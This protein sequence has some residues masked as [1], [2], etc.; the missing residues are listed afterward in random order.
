MGEQKVAYG[1]GGFTPFL[2]VRW[3]ALCELIRS[4]ISVGEVVRGLRSINVQDKYPCVMVHNDW[5]LPE[6]NTIG[7]YDKRATFVIYVVTQGNSGE[8]A[9]SDCV[10]IAEMVEKLLSNNALNDLAGAAP[11]FKYLNYPSYW[12]E[13]KVGQMKVAPP[14]PVQRDAGSFWIVTTRIPFEINWVEIE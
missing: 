6:L 4:N 10:D 2:K 1:P 14:I 9:E 7:K 3:N 13:S 8:E 11:S 12:N 5:K